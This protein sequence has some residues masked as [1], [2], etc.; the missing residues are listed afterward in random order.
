MASKKDDWKKLKTEVDAIMNTTKPMRKEMNRNAALYAGELW[1]DRDPDSLEFHAPGRS[2]VQF[3]LAFASVEAIAP[4]V[5]DNRPKARV[6]PVFPFM[7]KIGISLNN[8][9]K[10]IWSKE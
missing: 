10:Y 1:N 2:D 9:T 6:A 5:T 8:A 7:E 4:L 3:N